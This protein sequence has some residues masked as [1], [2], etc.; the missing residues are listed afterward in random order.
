MTATVQVNFGFSQVIACIGTNVNVVWQGYHNIQEVQGPSCGSADVG[1][2][3]WGYQSYGYTKEFSELGASPGETRYFKCDLHC[4]ISSARFEISCPPSASP[5]PP[6]PS[7]SPSPPPPS[8]PLSD[9]ICIEENEHVKLAS[10][11]FLPMKYVTVGT[12]LE[13]ASGGSTTV[14]NIITQTSEDAPYVI[15]MGACGTQS[16]TVLSPS[17]AVRCHGSWTTATEIGQRKYASGPVTYINLQT[18]DYCND[19]IILESGLVVETWDGRARDE[20]RPH[21][22]VNGKRISCKNKSR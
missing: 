2:D 15:P 8:I 5:S 20:W 7:A 16:P 22:Y 4:G 18:K 3:I 14:L 10:G 13:I 21:T 1:G 19:E 12:E 6:P 9:V 11:D 17:H